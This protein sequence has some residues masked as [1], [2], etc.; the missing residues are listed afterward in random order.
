MTTVSSRTQKA[1]LSG[2]RLSHFG[3]VFISILP[4]KT[5]KIPRSPWLDDIHAHGVIRRGEQCGL[6]WLVSLGHVPPPDKENLA[7]P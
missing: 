6:L 7:S 4:A 5:T 1:V 3:S 2:A